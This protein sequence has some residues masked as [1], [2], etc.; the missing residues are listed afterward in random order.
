MKVCKKCNQEKDYTSFYPNKARRD[1]YNSYCNACRKSYTESKKDGYY[2]VYFIP[3]DNY[4]GVTNSTFARKWLH[5]AEGRN[6][7]KYI[8]LGRFK[9]RDEAYRLETIY[10]DLG[11]EGRHK[12]NRYV[13]KTQ[14]ID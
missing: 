6:M 12:T 9:E 2:T 1:G 7:N 10:H 5:T 4:V 3:Q 8:T 13:R 14:L 11:Y